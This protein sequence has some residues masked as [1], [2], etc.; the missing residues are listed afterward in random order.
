MKLVEF[1]KLSCEMRESLLRSVACPDNILA[2]GAT[3]ER[4]R[5]A[6]HAALENPRCTT[7]ALE[8]ALVRLLPGDWKGGMWRRIASNP[9]CSRDVFINLSKHPSIWVRMLAVESPACPPDLVISAL[10]D[11]SE[12]VREIALAKI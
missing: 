1:K 6:I 12:A 5:Y 7:A 9:N 11:P 8:A 4:A 2:Y 3:K 10:Y